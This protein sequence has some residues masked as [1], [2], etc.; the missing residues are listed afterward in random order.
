MKS[1]QVIGQPAEMIFSPRPRLVE[2]FFHPEN[3]KTEIA[4]SSSDEMNRYEIKSTLLHDKNN[5]YIGRVFVARDVTERV[6]LQKKLEKL[7]ENLEERVEK[8]TKELRKSAEQYRTVVENQTEF[9]VR[10]RPDRTRTFVNDAYCRYFG[11]TQEEA[12]QTD[13]LTLVLEE[14]RKQVEEKLFRLLSRDVDAETTANR[15]VKPDGS[16][17]WQEWVDQAIYDDAGQIIEFQSVGRDI[18]ER[19]HAEETI[20]DQLA[21]NEL[22]TDLLSQF[23]MCSASEIDAAIQA[24]LQKVLDF[25]GGD[26]AYIFSIEEDKNT[27]SMIY[28][29]CGTDISS[30]KHNFQKIP[31][32][33]YKW[34]EDKLVLGK[35]IRINTLD[36]Y[37]PNATTV[38][39]IR[40][41]EGALSIMHVP[42]NGHTGAITGIIGLDSHAKQINWS[43]NDV[44]RLKMIGD[45]IANLLERKRAEENLLKAYDTTLA[46]WAKALEMRDKETKDHSQRVTDLTVKLAQAMGIEGDALTQMRR[47]AILHDIGKMAIPDEILRKRGTL[48]VP[49]RKVIEQHPIHSFELLSNIP[50]LE[51]ALE[52]PYCHHERWDGNGYPRGLK[53]EQIPL[54]ARIFTVI[55]VWDAVLSDRPYNQAWPKEKA[56]QY[57]K[58][59]SGIYFDPQCVTVFLDL[60]EKGKI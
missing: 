24:G 32:G 25:I 9:I 6:N 15:V 40:E 57:L 46:G 30:F 42:F 36:D 43:D 38:R 47:G 18:T 12:M 11:F 13:F 23:A 51:K 60:V 33:I 44:E 2:Q 8:R 27:L 37:P 21:F 14:D 17:G 55:D 19:K 7:N 29:W 54:A 28:E 5:R 26:H 58:E 35:A 10:W 41:A 50:F 56:I 22:M 53:G 48:T 59:Q 45:S 16:I 39:Q 31:L 34:S 3:I 20:Q 52:I 49:E 1:S 4:L